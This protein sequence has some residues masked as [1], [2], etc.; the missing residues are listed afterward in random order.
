MEKEECEG[1]HELRMLVS[2]DIINT[3]TNETVG[4]I[5]LCLNCSMKMHEKGKLQIQD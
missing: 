2:H 5:N 3:Q 1:C 4:T